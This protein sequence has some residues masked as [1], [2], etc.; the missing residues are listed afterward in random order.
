M[1]YRIYIGANN[2]TGKVETK[3]IVKLTSESFE[4]FT[5]Y[6]GVK[7]YWKGKAENSVILEIETRK[8]MRLKAMVGVLV[9]ELK[10]EAVG[11]AEVGKMRFIN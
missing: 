5:L 7:G 11:L 8:K 9:K 4:G 1:L 10:Q 2:K 3:K 6:E